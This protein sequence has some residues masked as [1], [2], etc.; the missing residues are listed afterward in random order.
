MGMM[1]RWLEDISVKLGYQGEINKKVIKE[2]QRIMKEIE[3]RNKEVKD[4]NR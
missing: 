4:D 1:K 3:K 2:G